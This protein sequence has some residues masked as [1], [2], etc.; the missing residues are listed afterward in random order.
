MSS[1]QS[2]SAWLTGAKGK[3]ITLAVWVVLAVLLNVIWPGVNQ[4][5]INN[6]P[7]LK[8]DKPSVQAGAVAAEEFPGGQGTPALVVW[9]RSGGLTDEDL[10]QVQQLAGAIGEK[11]LPEQ[12]FVVPLD[13]I[14]LPALK[15]QLSEDGSTIVS[16]ILF[17][18]SAE[19]DQLKTS[20][21]QFKQLVKST[22]GADPFSI[23][24]ADGGELTARVTGPVG[25]SIDATGLF[26]NAD[27]SLLLSTVVLVL[28][29]LLLIYRSPILALIPIV[30]VG[31]AYLVVSPILGI[32]AHEGWIIADSQSISIMTVLLFGAGTDYCLF[33]IS[34]FRQL[35]HEEESKGHALLRAL[36]SSSGAIAM[37]GFTVVLSLFSLLL[38]E[39]GSYH[40]FAVPF[41][42]SILIMGIASLTL[43]PALLSIIGRASFWPFIPR[44]PE[45]EEQ[46]ARDKGRS[47]P[48]RKEAKKRIGSLV[49]RR[50]LVVCIAAIVLL[51]GLAS[52][53][54]Q[55]KYTYDILSSFPKDMESRE[56]YDLIGK[57]F[58]PGELAPAKLMVNT[59][60]KNTDLKQRL[61]DLDYV[62]KVAEPQQG[63]ENP[64]ILAY[65]IEFSMNPYSIE[66][67]DHIPDL[68]KTAEAA[69][70]DAGVA[71][72]EDAVWISGQTATQYDT[73]VTGD[74]DTSVIIPVVIGLITL[75]LLVYLRSVVATVYLIATVILS[76][77][78]ALGLGWLIIHYGLGADA[79]QGA[80]PLYAFVFLVALGEDYNIFM[81]SS[82]W[83]KR[84]HMPLKEAV[85]EGVSETGAVITSA[86]IIL[87]GTFAVLASL[88]I[89]VLV[90]FGIIT[91]LGVLLDT[92]LVRPF[93]VPAITVLLGRWAFWP[94]KAEMKQESETAAPSNH[95]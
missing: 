38:A 30:A 56:G 84:K 71:S 58:S 89:Q 75:L 20:L 70:Q 45:M 77:F 40:R 2:K 37:S 43:V 12:K 83:E 16:T 60:G 1:K 9:H 80:I 51:G 66:A 85:K 15:A 33:L 32:M 63:K 79:I 49:V 26:K 29:I 47:T 68:R 17:N 53:S 48:K 5:E 44:T 95:G 7:N 72:P 73:K 91:A 88:P 92:F 65:D 55:I 62:D 22:L 52:F 94:G 35:L 82:I 23:K 8:E 59:R 78:S 13:Q 14:P 50:P 86:G 11:P 87:A 76:Y 54:P 69:L 39:Y 3:W 6:S 36:T 21:E 28:V 41:G 74:R 19:T 46:R 67:I 81:I 4:E 64:E 25:I 24:D 90:Q 34:R 61:A 31:F 57:Q 10:K 93:L 27:F 42:V 18:S